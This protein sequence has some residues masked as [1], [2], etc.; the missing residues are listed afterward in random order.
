MP[1][2]EP[3][4][5]FMGR[6]ARAT[7]VTV[8]LWSA[9]LQSAASAPANAA[10]LPEGP[11]LAAKYSDDKGVEKDPAVLFAEGFESGDLKRWDGPNQIRVV[12][13]GGRGEWNQRD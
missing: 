2:R 10:R 1:R 12:A 8:L 13:A 7:S 5:F 4:V 11:G 6:L 9:T 3:V